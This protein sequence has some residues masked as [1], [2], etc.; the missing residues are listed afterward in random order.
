MPEFW[1]GFMWGSL[2]AMPCLYLLAQV[3]IK[4]QR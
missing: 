3:F 2:A 1:T 4:I